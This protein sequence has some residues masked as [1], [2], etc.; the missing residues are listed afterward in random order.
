[1]YPSLEEARREL[2][3]GYEMNPGRWTKHS[4]YVGRAAGYIASACGMDAEKAEILGLLHDI[5]RR[6]GFVGIRHI[7]EGYRYAMDKGWDDVAKISMTHSF[8][9][10]RCVINPTMMDLTEEEYAFTVKFV[11]EAEF[12]DYDRL[13]HLC[14]NIGLHS[15][16][17]LMEKRMIDISMR[18]GVHEGTVARWEQLFA[19]KDYFERKMGGKSIYS[20]LPGVVENTFGF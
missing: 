4:E 9:E 11:S 2:A 15:G 20:V 10:N 19:L 7:V 1:M 17:V 14:D 16:F 6:V 18:H 5:G 12:D 8:A 13:I 3:T